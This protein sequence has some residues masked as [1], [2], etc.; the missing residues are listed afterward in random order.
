M[1]IFCV[2]R[3]YL[4]H[5]KELNNAVPEK[6][7]IFMKPPTAVL[8]DNKPFYH[9]E[10][11]NNIHHEVEIVIKICKNGKHIQK[12]FAND[13]F[14]EFTLGIDF[15]ARDLQDVLKAKGQ[16][17]EIAKAFDNSAV[18]GEFL[19]K[20]DY[21]INHLDFCLVRNG[22]KVQEGNTQQMIFD[23]PTIISYVSQFFMLQTGDL[24]YTGTPAGVGK[25][26]IN[27]V[28]DGFI[29]EKNIFHT[30]IK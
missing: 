25:I 2:G 27:D 14:K 16:P 12:K 9:P 19:S 10:F 29:Q 23:I 8:K 28:L 22:K 6:P 15:T 20:S 26:E 17:W 1:K 11:S 7:L 5:A 30:E 21:N 3:N 24:I 4:D 13:Y 18:L